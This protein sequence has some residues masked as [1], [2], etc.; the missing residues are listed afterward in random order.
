[1]EK[2]V[3]SFYEKIIPKIMVNN[4]VFYRAEYNTGINSSCAVPANVLQEVN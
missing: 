4:I 3:T 1:M 2:R